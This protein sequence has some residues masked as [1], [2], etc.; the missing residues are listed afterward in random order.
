[1]NTVNINLIENCFIPF[2]FG[3]MEQVR[4]LNNVQYIIKM[5]TQIFKTK[6]CS[7]FEIIIY[8]R[9]ALCFTDGIGFANGN[10]R[11]SYFDGAGWMP[12]VYTMNGNILM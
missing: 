9:T 3:D 2:W 4:R 10:P 6:Y 12:N 7:L 5:N 1:M 11:A 8:S